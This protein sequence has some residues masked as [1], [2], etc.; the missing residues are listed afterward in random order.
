VRGVEGYRVRNGVRDRDSALGPKPKD[1]AA[2]VEQ[3]RARERLQRAQREL[4]L[5]QR[6]LERSKGLGIGR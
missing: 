2:Q 3:R 1:R 6:T 4:K 5:K